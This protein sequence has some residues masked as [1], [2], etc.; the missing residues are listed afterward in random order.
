MQNGLRDVI[1]ESGVI[2]ERSVD[3]KLKG[4]AY[5]RPVIDQAVNSISQCMKLVCDFHGKVLWIGWR[6]KAFLN[7]RALSRCK[8]TSVNLPAM[9]LIQKVSMRFWKIMY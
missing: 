2:D 5:N 6:R 3:G 9:I 7:T 4:E 1:I 8:V